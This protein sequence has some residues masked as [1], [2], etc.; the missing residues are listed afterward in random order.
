MKTN[1]LFLLLLFP[2]MTFGQQFESIVDTTK[3]WSHMLVSPSWGGPPP[4]TATTNFVK[5][6]TDTMPGSVQ[7]KKV[8]SASDSAHLAWT[9]AG[10]I[11]EDATGKVYYRNVQDTSEWLLYDFGAQVGDTVPVNISATVHVDMLVDSIDSVYI[12]NRFRKR[13]LF[14]NCYE[15]W[16]EGIGST[17]GMLESGHSNLV[18]AQD[19]L[20]CFYKNDTLLYS[21]SQFSFCYYNNVGLPETE[22]TKVRLYP[23]PVSGT[24]VL[25]IENKF[26][27]EHA[28]VEI[29]SI[30]GEKLRVMNINPDGKMIIDGSAFASGI[31]IYRLIIPDAEIVA[32]KFVVE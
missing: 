16:I 25:S 22:E 4:N 31:Y 28:I 3:L 21:D 27:M 18:G 12:Y 5:F 15:S 6:T 10:L 13:I 2:L 30:A 7:Y 29:Y 14:E 9:L 23:N 11:R 19:F 20:L 1:F 24:S 8:L 26:A 32:G 17:C